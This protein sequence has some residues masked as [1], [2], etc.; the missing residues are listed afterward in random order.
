[1]AESLA[2]SETLGRERQ[3]WQ[4]SL[5]AL[6]IVVTAV[7]VALALCAWLGGDG[8]LLAGLLVPPITA[9]LLSSGSVGR[10]VWT[11]VVATLMSCGLAWSWL[12]PKS[13]D[14]FRPDTFMSIAIGAGLIGGA[15]VL[16]AFCRKSVWVGVL[17]VALFWS[18]LLNASLMNHAYQMAIV[19]G[20]MNTQLLRQAPGRPVQAGSASDNEAAAGQGKGAE[21]RIARTSE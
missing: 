15:L 11:A 20:R 16:I 19:M 3:R 4:F 5:R 2:E 17:V 18:L 10:R 14:I 7:G 9:V 8:L 6:L 13:R 1:M 21:E 12:F